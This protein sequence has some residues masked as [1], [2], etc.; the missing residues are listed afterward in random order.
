MAKRD[1]KQLNW[2]LS[3]AQYRAFFGKKA[4]TLTIAGSAT[5][6]AKAKF[7]AK[8][9][10]KPAKPQLSVVTK[11]YEIGADRVLP[12]ALT[13]VSA[14]GCGANVSLQIG[15]KTAA[16]QRVTAKRGDKTV[17]LALTQ[18]AY[19]AFDAG[20]AHRVVIAET[21]P[22]PVSATTSLKLTK[23]APEPDPERG[24]S[25]AYVERNWAPTEYDTCPAELHASFR[26][27]GPDG[28]Y[29]PTW[30]PAQATDPETGTICTFGHEHGADPATSNISDWVAQWYAPHDLIAGEPKGLPF[31]Y[32]S[33]ELDNYVHEHGDMSMRHE[34]NGG[35]KI[36]VANGVKML[37]ANRNWLK[38]PDGVQLTCDF[39]IKQHQGSW[40]PDATSNNAHEILYAAKCNDGTEI[41]TSM[42]SRFGNANEMYSTCATDTPISTVGSTLPAGDGGKRIIPTQECLAANATDWSLYELW[43]GENAVTSSDGIELARFDPWFGIRNPSRIYDAR[44]STATV[45]G[46][47]RPLD[48]AWLATGAPTDY[49]WSGL[50]AQERFDYRD[51]RSPF[52]GAQ[53]DFY[54]ADLQLADPETDGDVVYSDPYGGNA[55]AM[56]TVGSVPQLIHPGSVLG[57]VELARQKFDAKADFGARNGVHAPN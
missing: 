24:F 17:K 57:T 3:A 36:F 6:P 47:S 51:P 54:L 27:L 26:V 46:I 44:T 39:L 53:R 49:L 31:G 30:H 4:A 7:S 22:E 34:D 5:R 33:E 55:Q 25:K 32:T 15:G 29:Y 1:S 43:E 8:A 50:A 38:L 20:G 16:Q 9:M 28:K 11:S 41:I 18:S 12:L 37:D 48:L 56:P 14:Q 42:L 45:N 21:A 13:C 10:V 19:D 35:H 40:S 2:T 23:P 52:D